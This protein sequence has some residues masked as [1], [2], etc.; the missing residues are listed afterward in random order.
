MGNKWQWGASSMR[1]AI[2]RPGC[3][4]SGG[5]KKGAVQ[6]VPCCSQ[7][8][9]LAV[10]SCVAACKSH[11]FFCLPACQSFPWSLAVTVL[12]CSSSAT[13]TGSTSVSTLLPPS[14]S[15]RMKPLMVSGDPRTWE[16]L[17]NCWCSCFLSPLSPCI[18]C[19]LESRVHAD[20]EMQRGGGL[21]RV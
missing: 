16:V 5:A 19:R 18:L 11:C 10:S 2:L 21:R 3:V 6:H 17:S 9:V 14:P 12:N 20:W 13:S 1:T 4:R 7:P 8:S 15:C